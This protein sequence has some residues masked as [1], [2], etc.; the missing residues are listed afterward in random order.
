MKA[1]ERSAHRLHAGTRVFWHRLVQADAC[2]V[3]MLQVCARPY[4]A[5][6][7]GKDSSA[8]LW[9][10]LQRWPEARVRCLTGGE[11][12]LLHSEIDE[13]AAWWKVRFPLMDLAEVHVDHVFA[14]EWS[15]ADFDEQY[16]SFHPSQLGTTEW[17]AYLHTS[18]DWDGVFLGLRSDESFKR[19]VQN[20][21]RTEG[22]A[23]PIR[24]YSDARDDAAAGMYVACPLATWSD[25]DVAA[26]IISEGLPTLS[27]Y[28]RDGF[29][30]RTK[31]R[32]GRTA[33]DL[34][35]VA[36][37]RRRDPAAYNRLLQR[38]PEL[39]DQS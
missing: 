19:R 26:L 39:G 11:S 37:L 10:V 38:F 32:L 18:G 27:T 25:Q 14:A 13:H 9:L 16:M 21:H 34:G 35:Q 29:G 36:E 6:S 17:A 28:E 12:R 24:R 2:V 22:C 20:S 30:A 1:I 31:L 5:F 33:M 4:V 3:E 23:T 7:F 15:E 8:L